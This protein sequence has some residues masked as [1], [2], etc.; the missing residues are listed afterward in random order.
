MK[1]TKINK[2]IFTLSNDILDNDIL[3]NDI[4]DNDILDNDILDND[5]LD[6][7]ILVDIEDFTNNTNLN[8]IIN[9]EVG[10]RY[11][12]KNIFK[13]YE[14]A[15]FYNFLQN[16]EYLFF[17]NGYTG[18]YKD[19]NGDKLIAEFFQIN[20]SK[21]GIEKIYDDNNLILYENNYINNKQIE[22]KRFK[23]NK[24]FTYIKFDE[25]YN[26]TKTYYDNGEINESYKLVNINNMNFKDG[27]YN[28]YYPNK[29]INIKCNYNKG[30]KY[31]LYTEYWDNG[32]IKI[33]CEYEK[34]KLNGFYKEYYVDGQIKI[35]TNYKNNKYEGSYEEYIQNK[36]NIKCFYKHGCLDGEYIKYYNE[37]DNINFICN[38]K[39]DNT[40]S[41]TYL[42]KNYINI[43]I[44]EKNKH[45]EYIEF[46]QSGNIYIKGIYNN[47]KL[48]GEY[49][50]YKENG[51]IIKTIN[52]KN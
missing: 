5:I 18:I 39:C 13:T 43:P 33:E 1:Y 9:F 49:T 24:L 3:E 45:G 31:G 15:F 20:G 7:N 8:K 17:E 23:N 22:Q 47:N 26:I 21:E 51:E 40:D 11:K 12:F 35:L 6:N 32:N 28:K 34:N 27:E 44:C 16:H 37:T 52:Y 42:E 29:K 2:Y 25:K 4:L 41:I 50:F 19:Y 14:Q 36:L 30:A 10:G 46:Y 48:C 38:Y